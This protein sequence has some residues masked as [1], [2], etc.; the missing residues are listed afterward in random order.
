MLHTTA[1]LLCYSHVGVASIANGFPSGNTLDAWFNPCYCTSHF[2][3]ES[4][5]PFE[6][7]FATH[8]TCPP[9]ASSTATSLLVAMV[10]GEKN[11]SGKVAPRAK[12]QHPLRLR[13]CEPDLVL[14]GL[15]RLLQI[16]TDFMDGR[17][18]FLHYYY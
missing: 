18:I 7:T 2:M 11:Q 12:G 10:S 9:S 16:E 3:P 14:T 15:T 13:Q 4:P 6:A 17:A 1:L 8:L 5:V